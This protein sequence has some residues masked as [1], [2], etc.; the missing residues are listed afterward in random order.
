M[1]KNRPVT[2]QSTVLVTAQQAAQ[3]MGLSIE[4]IRGRIK[5]KTIPT[6]RKKGRVYVE[7]IPTNTDQSTDQVAAQP[8]GQSEEQKQPSERTSQISTQLPLDVVE[9]ILDGYKGQIE[10]LK[11]VLEKQE[12]I[13][14]QQA[15]Q[16]ERRLAQIERLHADQ[17]QR[18]DAVIIRMATEQNGLLHLAD[19]MSERVRA[20]PEAYRINEVYRRDDS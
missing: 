18:L 17:V 14:Q 20:L 1:P 9:T 7:V 10:T 2:D 6:V 5:R 4:A 11:N 8:T 3:Q 16:Y 15:A 12:K 13:I 19:R